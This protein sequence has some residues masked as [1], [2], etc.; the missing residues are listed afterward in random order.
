MNKFRLNC[1]LGEASEAIS[2]ERNQRIMPYIDEANIACGFHAGDPVTA[3]STLKTAVAHGVSVGAHPSYPDRDNF[4]RVSISRTDSELYADTLYQVAGLA[5]LA[6]A[7]GT[8]LEWLKPH[9]ALYH[10]MMKQPSVMACM[11]RVCADFPGSLALVVQADH[12][13]SQLR[14]LATSL[15]IEIRFEA[16]A[17][18]RYLPDGSL[19]PRSIPG[20]V[21]NQQDIIEQVTLLLE[22]QQ[23]LTTSG[24][25]L[26]I[27]A[28]TVCI[29]GDTNAAINVVQ[30]LRKRLAYYD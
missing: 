15:G 16:F 10:D 22:H 29:H 4:G 12:Q 27:D 20:A 5:G 14:E 21:L 25:L 30:E 2:A 28:D 3:L 26:A 1:D 11:M 24:E 18:R 23:V 8:T 9:G 6:Q 7:A 19:Q 17:D 13:Q